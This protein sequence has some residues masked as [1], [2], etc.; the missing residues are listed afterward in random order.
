MSNRGRVAVHRAFGKSRNWTIVW[1]NKR[2]AD[3]MDKLGAN[4]QVRYFCGQGEISPT[5][6]VKHVQAYVQFLNPKS[7]HYV[8]SLLDGAH[9]ERAMGTFEENK[10]YCS[11]AETKNPDADEAFVEMGEPADEK[12]QGK[13]G[14]LD[15]VLADARLGK[16][17]DPV[18]STLDNVCGHDSRVPSFSYHQSEFMS[19]H[20]GVWIKH[21]NLV[22]RIKVTDAAS[23]RKKSRKD[24]GVKVYILWGATGTGKSRCIQDRYEGRLFV[25]PPTAPGGMQ[26]YDGYCGEYAALFEEFTGRVHIEE[27]LRIT[28]R[29]NL[30]MPVKGSFV[31]WI[32]KVILFTSNLEPK[33]WWLGTTTTEEQRAAF[34]RRVTAVHEM[35]PA[36]N[37]E[38]PFDTDSEE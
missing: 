9:L 8:K 25:A 33:D 4:D 14:D 11:K 2:M 20:F 6:A 30:K 1:N 13:R 23:D 28:D 26:W 12:K 29:Y 19:K 17:D 15:S 3:L 5:N 22:D 36:D 35:T 31:D 34:M 10:A 18:G 24:D 21:P 37:M 32:P 38:W 27:T 7:F 16:L